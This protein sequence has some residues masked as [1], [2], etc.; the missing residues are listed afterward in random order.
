MLARWNKLG[1][2]FRERESALVQFNGIFQEYHPD[3]SEKTEGCRF[4]GVYL[5]QA[6]FT[7]FPI[8]LNQCP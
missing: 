2:C 8:K 6:D 4:F 5:Q 1:I 3:L 7:Q